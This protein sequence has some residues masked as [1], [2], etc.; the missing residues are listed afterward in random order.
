MISIDHDLHIHTYL[1]ACCHDKGNQRPANIVAVAQTLGLKT[2][3][4]A[5]HVWSNRQIEPSS[6]YRPQDERQIERL[7]HDLRSVSSPVRILVGCE[8]DTVAPGRFSVTREFAT[9]VD[10]VGLSCSHL[11]LKDLVQQPADNTPEAVGCLLMDLFTSGIDS[12]VATLIVHPFFPFGF[13]A[14]FDRAIASLTDAQF[15]DAFGLAADRH[16]ALE[17]T[18]SF[19]PPQPAT[20]WS[21]DTPIRVLTLAKQAG[22]RFTLGSDAHE[23]VRMRGI[24]GLEPLLRQLD[25]APTDFAPIVRFT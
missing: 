6:W 16:V 18:I 1:S 25:L 24:L 2:I 3:G 19:I 23:L 14:V 13:E 5:D 12:G 20:P 8:A 15:L 9:T 21:I 10:Y 11:H 17:I 4:F 7:R 22:C